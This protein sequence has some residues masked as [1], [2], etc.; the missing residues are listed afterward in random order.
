MVGRRF[1]KDTQAGFSLLEV[2]I[3]VSILSVAAYVALDAVDH[4]SSELRYNLTETRLEKI[5]RAIVGDPSLTLNGSPMIS[6]YVADVGQLPPCLE[7]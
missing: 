4:D 2:L 7:A 6:G 3:V 5:R 1:I